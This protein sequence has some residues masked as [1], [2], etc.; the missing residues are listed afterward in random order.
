MTRFM[1]AKERAAFDKAHAELRHRRLHAARK[2]AGE[3]QTA[4]GAFECT[5]TDSDLIAAQRALQA[6]LEQV[7][8]ELRTVMTDVLEVR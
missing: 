3:A 2:A 6:A 8:A 7:T 5:A 4:L 1:S